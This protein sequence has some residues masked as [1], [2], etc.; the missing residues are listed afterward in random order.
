MSD[1]MTASR[2]AVIGESPARLARDYEHDE[3][4]GERADVGHRLHSA[5]ISLTELL[6]KSSDV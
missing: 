3:T 1:G 5:I 6:G 2:D 4:E